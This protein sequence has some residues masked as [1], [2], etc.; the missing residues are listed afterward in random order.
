MADVFK[1]PMPP[2]D[3]LQ[4]RT[5]KLKCGYHNYTE[6]LHLHG[7]QPLDY[8]IM[9]AFVFL[10]TLY[11]RLYSVIV[12]MKIT[13]FWQHILYKKLQTIQKFF[14]LKLHKG[15]ENGKKMGMTL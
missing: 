5:L 9:S 14:K 6:L 11:E 15:V 7:G 12:V 4:Y 10:Q 13:I 1:C 2:H 8:S 3:W